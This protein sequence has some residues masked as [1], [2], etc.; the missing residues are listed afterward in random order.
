[1]TPAIFEAD[2]LSQAC[3]SKIEDLAILTG[4][5][6]YC[7]KCFKCRNCKKKIESLRYARTSQGIFCMS[8]HK[9]LIARRK[10]KE[11]KTAPQE[12]SG[13]A[14]ERST[15]KVK[16]DDDNGDVALAPPS[17]AAAGLPTSQSGLKRSEA[18]AAA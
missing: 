15:P 10:K 12:S 2:H 14:D 6:A 3:G 5:Q 4:D 16:D 1:L 7:A 11:V 9:A 13:D 17:T 8:C 18:D